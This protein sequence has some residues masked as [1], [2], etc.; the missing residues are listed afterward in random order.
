MLKTFPKGGIHPPENKITSER[1]IKRMTVPKVVNVPIAQHIGI[2]AEIVVDRKD[3]VDMVFILDRSGSM[4]AKVDALKQGI[5]P[6]IE[7]FADTA[8]LAICLAAL[9]AKGVS[10]E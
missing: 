1:K 7:A 2:P 6:Y 4:C 8:P 3:K 9:K 10:Y 5:V